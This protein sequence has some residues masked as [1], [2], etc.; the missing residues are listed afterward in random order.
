[1]LFSPETTWLLHTCGWR[2]GRRVDI[3]SW[4]TDVVNVGYSTFPYLEAILT[5]FGGL[6]GQFHHGERI[7][8]EQEQHS[9]WSYEYMHS[10]YTF[11]FNL[12]PA[13]APEYANASH[14]RQRQ[15]ILAHKL[16]LAPIGMY[17]VYPFS[18]PHA[19]TSLFLTSNGQLLRATGWQNFSVVAEP[20]LPYLGILGYSFEEGLN[21]LV[22]EQVLYW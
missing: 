20:S 11:Q 1:M 14:W 10:A 7:H 12:T 19:K 5:E 16:E 17:S 6:S 18:D 21:R 3:A 13:L 9:V 22:Q 4:I 8:V 15:Y 2:V